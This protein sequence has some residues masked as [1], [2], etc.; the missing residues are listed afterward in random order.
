VLLGALGQKFLMRDKTPRP[1]PEAARRSAPPTAEKSA[2]AST[3]REV[4]RLIARAYALFEK[5][6]YTRSNLAAAEDFTRKATELAT[7][8]ARAWGARAYVQACYILR[9]WDTSQPR[10]ETAQ[11]FANRALALDSQEVEALLALAMMLNQQRAF[12]QADAIARRAIALR[13]GD[14]RPRRALG[15]ALLG[16]GRADEALANRQENVRLFPREPLIYYDL[17]LMQRA[18]GNFAGAF[19]SFEQALALEPFASVL[20]HKT[21]LAASYTGDLA[22]ARAALDRLEPEDRTEDRAV[23]VA[24][25]L[26]L[27]EHRPDRVIE[28]AALTARTYLDDGIM[29]GAKA[30]W[31]ALAYQLDGKAALAR[32]QWEAAELVLRQRLADPAASPVDRALWAITLAWLG[33]REDAA[34]EIA[35]FEATAREQAVSTGTPPQVPLAFFD[36]AMGDAAKAVA[37]ARQGL[38]RTHFISDHTLALDPQWDKIRGSPEFVA[39]LAEA[40]AR[41]SAT[42]SPSSASSASTAPASTFTLSPSGAPSPA[43]ELAAKAL[44]L[45][46]GL[47]A[48]REDFALAEDYC[49]RALKLDSTDGDIWA[50]YSSL[51][52]AFV[53]RGWEATA[54]R[55]EQTRV[56]AERAI[57]LAPASTEAKLAQAG[58]WST[59]N[60]NRPEMEKLLREVVAERP[61]DQAALRFLAVA[62]LGRPG[63]LDDCLALNERSAALPGGD[64][65]ALYNNARYLWQRGRQAEAY[66]TLQRSLAQKPFSSSLVLKTIMEMTWRGDLA[67]AEATLNQIPQSALLEDRANYEAGLVRFYQRRADAALAVWGAFPRESYSDFQ[68]DGPKGLIIGL[69]YDLDHRDAAAKI[70]W[71]TAL[72]VAEKRLAAAPNNPARHYDKAYLLACLGEKAAAEEELRTYEQLAGIKFTPESPMTFELAL[73]YARLGRFDDIFAQTPARFF[74]RIR[75]DPRFDGMRSDPRYAKQLADYEQR[76]ADAKK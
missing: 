18:Q 60:V 63:G 23:G 36:A 57:R 52:G 34:R 56:M 71:R 74:G 4:D 29:R 65:L 38:N 24:E 5:M 39:L 61:G 43:R 44:A 16:A 42:T 11:E 55:R 21:M 19:A 14:S 76:K 68:Y 15:T 47:E 69:A 54:E 64:P 17:A 6:S 51:N 2:A 27:L 49:Q 9:G 35:A 46:Q 1:A 75:I 8:S 70:E 72:Q 13:P 48:T 3:S 32:Q 50:V 37:Y 20:L 30:F 73:I 7:D 62:V 45:F 22:G 12:T 10:R 25:W 31:V 53:Y 28:A 58:A 67:A 66:A 40:K 59:F 41:T 26:G 33:R